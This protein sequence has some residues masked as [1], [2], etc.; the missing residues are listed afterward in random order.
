MFSI[1]PLGLAHLAVGMFYLFTVGRRI[2]PERVGEADLSGKYQVRQFLAEL[3]VKPD[4]AAIAGL[5]AYLTR[6]DPDEVIVSV[7]T[8]HGLKSTE[9]TIKI[10]SA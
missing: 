8:G 6:S 7:F 3:A 4:A 9:T 1:A 5:R 2:I 10:L